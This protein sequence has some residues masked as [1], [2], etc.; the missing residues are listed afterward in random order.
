MDCVSRIDNNSLFFLC[1]FKVLFYILIN[2]N[3][4]YVFHVEAELNY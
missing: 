4:F 2:K 1:M 3:H